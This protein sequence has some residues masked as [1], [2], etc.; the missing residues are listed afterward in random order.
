VKERDKKLLEAIG[1]KVY[2]LRKK[3][4][5]SQTDLAFKA[6]K[7]QYHISKIENGSTSA[8]I[9][10]LNAIAIALKVSLPELFTFD[11]LDKK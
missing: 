4:G 10:T 11:K 3:E 8:S 6:G 2:Q 9:T 7:E 5:L 1:N